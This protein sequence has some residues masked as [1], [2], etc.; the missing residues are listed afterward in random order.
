MSGIFIKRIAKEDRKYI[1]NASAVT[2]K[3]FGPSGS[4]IKKNTILENTRD[5]MARINR[6]IFFDMGYIFL[7]IY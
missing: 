6:E 7:S 3:R 5:V 1:T 4:F 2:I